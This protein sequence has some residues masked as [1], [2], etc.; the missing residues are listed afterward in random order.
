MNRA[1][2]VISLLLSTMP[3]AERM[4]LVQLATTAW[5]I[6]SSTLVSSSTV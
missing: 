2:Q 4:L 5:I 6:V 3:I 1:Q